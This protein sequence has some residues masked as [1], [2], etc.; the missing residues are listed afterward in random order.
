MKFIY[1]LDFIC[2][3]MKQCSCIYFLVWHCVTLPNVCEHVCLRWSARHCTYHFSP[4]PDFLL[5]GREKRRLK[6]TPLPAF[7]IFVCACMHVCT[8]LVWPHETFLSLSGK[9]MG[10][11]TCDVYWLQFSM[12]YGPCPWQVCACLYKSIH[13]HENV[14]VCARRKELIRDLS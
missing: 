1:K 10:N 11:Q 3:W 2:I 9:L 6:V 13:V 4:D 14:Y 12:L 8:W 7:V 5:Q